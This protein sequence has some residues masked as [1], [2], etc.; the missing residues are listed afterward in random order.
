MGSVILL[1]FSAPGRSLF[2]FYFSRDGDNKAESGLR[3]RREE[4]GTLRGS[5]FKIL[6]IN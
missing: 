3:S 6:G 5:E 1:P 4:P 2:A